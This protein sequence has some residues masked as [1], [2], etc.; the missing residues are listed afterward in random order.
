MSHCM[1][2]RML[3]AT[4]FQSLSLVVYHERTVL[5]NNKKNPAAAD[6]RFRNV[7]FGGN[8]KE[9][10]WRLQKAISGV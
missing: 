2:K 7:S 6:I 3:V 5:S 4:V 9:E 10:V 8:I 1:S